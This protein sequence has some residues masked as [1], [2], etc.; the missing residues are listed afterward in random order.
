MANRGGIGV[1]SASVVLVF[2]VLCLSVFSLITL[3]VAS[4]DKALAA[5]EA[6]LVVGYYEA[7][8]LAELVLAELLSADVVPS[9]I[10]GIDINARWNEQLNMDTVYF[11]C[12]ISDTK[13]LYVYLAFFEDTYNILSWR[14][15]NTDD[16]EYRPGLNVWVGDLS[17]D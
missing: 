9:S 15:I 2:A 4:N 13:V 3:V 11:Y 7:D 14:M 17:D 5:S 8:T 16:W 12:H 10:R 1:G 6:K